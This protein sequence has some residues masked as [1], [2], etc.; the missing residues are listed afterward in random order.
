MV[1]CGLQRADRA[2]RADAQDVGEHGPAQ[3]REP[4][5]RPGCGRTGCT[6]PAPSGQRGGEHDG[7]AAAG[8]AERGK[9]ADAEDQAGR[10]RHQQ[11][12]ADADRQ[13]EGTNMLPVPR[14]TLASAFI[15]HTSTLPANTTLE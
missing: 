1:R 13:A 8:D 2:D 15:S 12:D 3:P 6:R 9:R 7:H 4:E 11:H 14:M 10:Q 5:A